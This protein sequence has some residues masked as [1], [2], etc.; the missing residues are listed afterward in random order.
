MSSASSASSAV[1]PAAGGGLGAEFAH[2]VAAGAS[3]AGGFVPPEPPVPHPP[4]A[5]LAFGPESTGLHEAAA[6]LSA[7]SP[8]DI[9]HTPTQTAAA[10]AVGSPAPM[11]GSMGSGSSPEPP[12]NSYGSVLSTPATPSASVAPAMGSPTGAAG[13]PPMYPPGGTAGAAA[14]L[15]TVV[16]QDVRDAPRVPMDVA[17]SDLELARRAV[18]ELIHASRLYGGLDWAVGVARGESGA[19]EL[20]V[21]SNEGAGYIPAGVFLPRNFRLAFGRDMDF[22]ARWFG[23]V[24]PAESVVR[25]IRAQGYSLS[26]VATS[27]F[28]PSD[29][30]RDSVRESAVGVRPVLEPSDRSP[31]LVPG[32]LHRLQTIAPALYQAL[33]RANTYDVHRYCRDVTYAAIYGGHDTP[34]PA[35]ESVVRAVLSEQAAPQGEWQRVRDE[36]DT[37]CMLAGSQRPGYD[38]ANDPSLTEMYRA[39]FIAARRLETLLCWS[40]YSLSAADL[41]YSA[42]QAGASIAFDAAAVRS[43]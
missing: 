26:A 3:A 40:E 17:I 29:E 38:G 33:E 8:T 32:R 34:S 27:F 13:A 31:Q 12:L 1:A 19:P 39:D 4:A 5:P 22:D 25:A 20:V 37:A 24:N 21:A 30:V 10:P 41:V 7:P 15:G 2:G 9:P 28:A 18:Q 35:V 11:M 14:G 36:Y 43:R 16:P 23:W 6:P 42:I